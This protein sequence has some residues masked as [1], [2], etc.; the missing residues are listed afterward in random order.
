MINKHGAS[1]I[2]SY[3]VIKWKT[4]ATDVTVNRTGESCRTICRFVQIRCNTA[5]CDIYT[6]WAVPHI[7]CNSPLSRQC[8]VVASQDIALKAFN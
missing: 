6:P 3:V 1:L 8:F 7:V 5:A 2:S 4:R